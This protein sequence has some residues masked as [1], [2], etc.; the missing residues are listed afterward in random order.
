MGLCLRSRQDLL[1]L[2]YMAANTTI[3]HESF[4]ILFSAGLEK[5]SGQ[6]ALVASATTILVFGTSLA[7]YRGPRI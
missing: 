2:R 7:L 3:M 4:R 6:Q 1:S 5:V